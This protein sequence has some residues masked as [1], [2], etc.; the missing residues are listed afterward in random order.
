[1]SQKQSIAL[2]GDRDQTVEEQMDRLAAVND[3]VRGGVF[4]QS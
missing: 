1:M 4:S 3:R 2:I